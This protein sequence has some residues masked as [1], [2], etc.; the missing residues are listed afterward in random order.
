MIDDAL[1]ESACARLSARA[2][3]LR[4]ALFADPVRR[5]YTFQQIREGI[6]LGEL[7]RDFEG[8]DSPR[9]IY[10]IA[11]DPESA[12]SVL[13]AFSAAAL[14]KQ[15]GYC[16]PR[17]VT[18]SPKPTMYVGSSQS[19]ASRL[20]QHLN[21]A[22]GRTYALNMSRWC[23]SMEGIVHISIQCISGGTGRDTFQDMEDA[24]WLAREPMFGRLGSR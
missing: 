1:L 17:L 24:L 19:I 15:R 2:A 13:E 8:G 20:H 6:S 18:K 9:V 23:P 16:L 5:S 14:N 11:V 21:K 7:R 22:P 10:I 4:S 3:A 12:Q